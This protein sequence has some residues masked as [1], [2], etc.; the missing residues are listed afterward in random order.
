[1]KRGHLVFSVKCQMGNSPIV[2]ITVSLARTGVLRMVLCP[3]KP[4]MYS[5]HLLSQHPSSVVQCSVQD[6]LSLV[7]AEVPGYDS[8]LVLCVEKPF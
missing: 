1:M 6:W 2:W 8:L 5:G 7:T 3:D 4:G